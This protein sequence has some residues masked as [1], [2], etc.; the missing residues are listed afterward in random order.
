MNICYLLDINKKNVFF[1]IVKSALYT[2]LLHFGHHNHKK[3]IM[4]FVPKVVKIHSKR[5]C[6]K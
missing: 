2:S 6:D 3:K 1:S 4:Q 5:N